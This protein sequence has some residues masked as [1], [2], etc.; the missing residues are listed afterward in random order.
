[1]PKEYNQIT[2]EIVKNHLEKISNFKDIYDL[3]KLL[4][5]PDEIIYPSPTRRKKDSFNFKKED[6]DRIKEVYSII[7]IGEGLSKGDNLQVFFIECNSISTKFTRDVTKKLTESYRSLLVIFTDNYENIVF[8]LPEN[9]KEGDVFKLK[10]TRLHT[11]KSDLY[12]TDIDIVYR[13]VYEQENNWRFIFKKWKDAFSVERVQDS[14]F[15]DYKKVFFKVRDYLREQKVPKKESHEF[16]LQ[17]LNRIMFIYFISKKGWLREKKFISFLW[18]EYKKSIEKDAFYNKWLKQIF[19]KAFNGRAAEISGIS[20]SMRL[21]LLEYAPHLNGGLFREG[22]LDK[23]ESLKN[24]ILPDY[25]F[26][27]LIQDFFERYNFTIKEDMPLDQDVAVDPQMI[28]YVYESL[29]N[30]ADEIYD[31]NDL[32]IFYTPSIEVEFMCKRSLVEYIWNNMLDILPKEKIYHLLFDLPDLDEDLIEYFNSNNIWHR[33]EEVLDNL[34]VV[35]PACGSGAFLV[36]MLNILSEVYSYIHIQLSRN[37]P[38][39]DRKYRIIQRNLYGVDVM[40]WALHAA[41]LRLWLQLIVDSEF[42]PEKLKKGPLLPNLDMNLRRGDS[43]IQ[44]IG[45]LTFNLRQNVL[46]PELKKKLEQLKSEKQKYFESSRTGKFRKSEE[47]RKEE[48]SIF[49]EIIKQRINLIENKIKESEDKLLKSQK[50]EQT[51]LGE[52]PK[53]KVQL[54]I[55]EEKREKSLEKE[56]FKLKEELNNL[57]KLDKKILNPEEKPFVWDIN[58]AEI[59]GDKGGFDIVIGNPPYVRQE[60]IS[61]PNK[62]KSDVSLED[63]REYKKKLI[64]SVQSVFPIVTKIDKKSDYYIYFYFHGLGLLNKKGVFCF[65]TSNS[66]LDVGYGKELQEFILKYVPINAIYDNPKRSFEHADVNTIIALLGAPYFINMSKDGSIKEKSNVDWSMTKNVAKFVMFKKSFEEVLITKYLIEIDHVKNILINKPITELVKNVVKTDYFR[67]FPILQE[68]LLE[69][70]WEY[71]NDYVKSKGKFK[72]GNYAGNKW[73]AKYLRA[74][75]IYYTVL[76]KGKDKLVRLGDICKIKRGFTTGINEFFYLPSAYFDLKEEEEYYNL[77]PKEKTLPYNLKIEKEFLKSVIKSPKECK[78]IFI[79]ESEVKQKILICNL[80]LKEIKTKEVYNYIKWGESKGYHERPTVSS[81]NN[82]WN[83]GK[84]DISQALCMMSYNNRHIFWKNDLFLSDARFYDIY[85]SGD[86]YS[87]VLSLNS[88]LCY[89]NVELG[90]RVNL[91]E[92]AL[93]FK[94]YEAEKINILNPELIN[95]EDARKILEE[96]SKREI[97]SVFEEYGYEE[98]KDFVNQKLDIIADRKELEEIVLEKLNLD[99]Q[100]K[101][102]I[103]FSLLKLVSERMKKSNSFNIE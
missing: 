29:A 96:L 75:D 93:D 34:S 45:G 21:L 54:E 42:K 39:F 24:L 32:G 103:F 36:G 46:S 64:R 90:G 98:S 69:D 3:F 97:K 85:Y 82:W 92:G 1:V 35:D 77:L 10:L 48:I 73:G 52:R 74:P 87:L 5:Y 7:S 57:K 53:S 94:V 65:I 37:I 8:I 83:L 56:I 2:K 81:R 47:I 62:I 16:T 51:F 67:L 59:F 17:L 101:I 20:E 19:F 18:K 72:A 63:K 66:W 25:L 33:L 26:L 100:E 43:L 91:G 70:G 89:L 22:K 6:Q 14:F 31:R 78:S 76:E 27:E 40:P 71:P 60:M 41:E 4:N 30:V 86:P 38:D 80:N 55:E 13:L 15:E 58:F 68:D 12:Y 79:N 28:G 23:H 50:T 61:P 84:R 102:A 9:V 88:A 11:I 49:K 95:K 99:E 44:E